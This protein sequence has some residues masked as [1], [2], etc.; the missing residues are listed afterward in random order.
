MKNKKQNSLI[1]LTFV[2]AVSCATP[3]TVVMETPM[4]TER[5]PANAWT[6][7]FD[8]ITGF[9][10]PKATNTPP[11]TPAQVAAVPVKPKVAITEALAKNAIRYPQG[12]EGKKGMHIQYGFESEY[13][14]HESVELLKNYMPMSPHWKK[15][16]EDWLA[17]THEQRADFIESRSQQI[18]PYREKG[19]LVKISTDPELIDVLPESFVFD[20]GHYEVVLAPHDSAEALAEKIRVINRKLGVGSMQLTISNPIEKQLLKSNPALQVQMKEELMGYYN[21]MND[22]DTIGKLVTGYER[23]L[24]NPNTETV[25]SFNHPWLGPMTK[26]K[27]DR[28]E[29]LMSKILAGHEFND[30]ELA[31]MSSKVVSHKFIGGLSFRPDVAFK[32]SRLASEVRDCHQNVKC[33]ENRL[34]RETYFLMKGRND[35]KQYAELKAFDSESTFDK[36]D[37]PVRNFLRTIFPKYGQYSQ[38]EL[39]LFRNFAYPFRDWSKHVELLG[40]AKL[41]DS[42]TAAQTKYSE[43]LVTLSKELDGGKINKETARARVMGALGEFAVESGISDAVKKKFDEAI[44]ADELKL[45]EHLQLSMNKTFFMMRALAA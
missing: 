34:M 30:E 21:L 23:Y 7:C 18:F 31:G 12:F 9:F 45:F 17:L 27:H 2:L 29:S 19:Q 14:H 22:Y 8:S 39:E 44:D 28:L 10:N 11:V 3:P 36:L 13:L 1:A 25:K 40:D 15:S 16:K 6:S 43:A 35:F 5:E 4:P 42:I 41:A 20:A 32:K 37:R 33:I 38:T 24:K 26:L